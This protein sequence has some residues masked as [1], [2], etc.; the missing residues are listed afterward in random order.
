MSDGWPTGALERELY[1]SF[2]IPPFP[3]ESVERE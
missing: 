2:A 3:A 1:R